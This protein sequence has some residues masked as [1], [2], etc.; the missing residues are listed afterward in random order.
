MA[1]YSAP[2]VSTTKIRDSTM[3]FVEEH[4]AGPLDATQVDHHPSRL[5]RSDV[6]ASPA[7]LPIVAHLSTLVILRRIKKLMNHDPLKDAH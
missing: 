1:V 6:D 2:Y 5:E 3:L 7:V 4:G